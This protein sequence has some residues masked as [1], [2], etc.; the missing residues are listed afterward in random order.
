MRSPRLISVGCAGLVLTFAVIHW[1]GPWLT[2]EHDYATS[3]PQPPPLFT[4]SLIR[5]GPDQ[6]ACFPDAVMDHRSEVARFRVRT[7]RHPAQPLSLT[8]T[9]PGY[10]VERAVPPEY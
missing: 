7:L 4:L 1:W 6:R 2:R 3:I 5:L 10:R 8:L 9:A